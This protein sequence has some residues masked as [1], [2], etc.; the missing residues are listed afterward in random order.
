MSARIVWRNDIVA[1]ID[2][3]GQVAQEKMIYTILRYADPYTPKDTGNLIASGTRSSLP[4]QG[5]IIYSAPYAAKQYRGDHF[6]FDRTKNRKAG[7]R[8]IERTKREHMKNIE[9]TAQKDF[10]EAF[11]T[12]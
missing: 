2:K 12:K 4:K 9:Q 8:W 7:S 5:L 6:K 10:K 1:K 11:K 3:A